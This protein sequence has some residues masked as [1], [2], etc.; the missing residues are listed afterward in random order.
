MFYWVLW[1]VILKHIQILYV[2]FPNPVAA[3]IHRQSN[4]TEHWIL[5]GSLTFLYF[6]AS[7]QSF[8]VQEL[9][10]MVRSELIALKKEA[11]EKHKESRNSIWLEW[12]C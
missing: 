4:K 2:W 11:D 10:N 3:V 1:Y 5:L 12:N 9:T 7:F 6:T 8:T